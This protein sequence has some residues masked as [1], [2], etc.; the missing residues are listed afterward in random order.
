M[1][2]F[3]FAKWFFFTSKR[4][5]FGQGWFHRRCVLI[6]ATIVRKF[7][8]EAP[9]LLITYTIVASSLSG[10]KKKKGKCRLD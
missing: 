7:V 9:A 1:K 8:T 5:G 2:K 3:S 4:D 6:Y 10:P